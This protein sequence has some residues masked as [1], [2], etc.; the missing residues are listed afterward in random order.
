MSHERSGAE[1]LELLLDRLWGEVL[2]TVWPQADGAGF[3]PEWRAMCET[4]TAPA[5]LAAAQAAEA[6]EAVWA[7]VKLAARQ[8]PG[9]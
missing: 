4:R 7:S 3:G 2:P 8:P 6:A 9:A 5:A 1:Q